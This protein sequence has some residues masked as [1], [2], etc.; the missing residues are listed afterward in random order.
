MCRLA[1]CRC[2]LLD[3]QDLNAA[4]EIMTKLYSNAWYREHLT[5]VHEDHQV[6]LLLVC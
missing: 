3:S 5:T 1:E 4:G 2:V 6:C